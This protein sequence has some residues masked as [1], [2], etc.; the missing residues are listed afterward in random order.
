M[1]EPFPPPASKETLE[2]GDVFTPNFD[3]TGLIVCI[4]AEHGTGAILMVAYMNANALRATLDTGIVHYWSRSRNALWRKGDTSGQIQRLVS[5][6]TDCDQDALLVTVEV[7]GD[8]GCCHTGR[9]S[10]F[11]REVV[12]GGEDPVR[13]RTV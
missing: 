5:M 8:G 10:C 6:R 1:S 11:Y 13:L 12:P 4:T 7:G 3:A 9:H 2:E